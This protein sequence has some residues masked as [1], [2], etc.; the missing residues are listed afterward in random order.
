[1]LGYEEPRLR[2]A[3]VG[4]FLSLGTLP[5]RLGPVLR[6][7]FENPLSPAQRHQ[8]V[9]RYVDGR[10]AAALARSPESGPSF[11]D[12]EDFSPAAVGAVTEVVG[13]AL[14]G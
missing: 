14:A 1:M 11:T 10:I 13:E 8:A 9:Q 4:A 7:R 5:A 2:T 12:D 3:V 6:R